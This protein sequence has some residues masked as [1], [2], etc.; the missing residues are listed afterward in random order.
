MFGY[1]TTHVIPTKFLSAI[2]TKPYTTSFGSQSA[3]IC[4]LEISV[5]VDA[6][7]DLSIS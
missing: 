4:S 6:S 2:V 1:V 7:Y 5:V 3:Q